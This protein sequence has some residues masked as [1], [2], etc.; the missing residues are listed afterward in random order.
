MGAF[1]ELV[2]MVEGDLGAA[3][4]AGVGSRAGDVPVS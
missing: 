4:G 3:V 2:E 1:G